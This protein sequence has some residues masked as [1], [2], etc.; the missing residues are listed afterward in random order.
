MRL[1]LLLCFFLPLMAFSVIEW[2]NV[3]IDDRVSAS[4]PSQPEKM[5][6]GGNMALVSKMENDN[7]CMSMVIDFSKFGFDS[8]TLALEMVKP[9]AFEQFKESF[10]AQIPG[11]TLL[12]EK[13]TTLQGYTCYEFVVDMGKDSVKSIMHNRNVITG[14]NM[15]SFNFYENTPAEGDRNKF[16][17]SIKIK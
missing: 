8:A 7:G 17:N 10:L 5:D 2:V 12:S 13:N 9:E 16:L 3:D 1:P 11:A 4:F 6:L 15:Y 14:T